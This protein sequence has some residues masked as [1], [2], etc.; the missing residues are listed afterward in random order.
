MHLILY[1]FQ[2]RG[3]FYFHR[4]VP[5]NLMHHDGRSKIVFLLK[6]KSMR[7]AKVKAAS[8]ANELTKI[9]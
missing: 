1:L 6:T 3:I 8:L 7:A 9:G 2:T 5:T 4:R